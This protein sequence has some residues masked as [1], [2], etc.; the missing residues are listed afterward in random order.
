MVCWLHFHKWFNFFS[1]RSIELRCEAKQNGNAADTFNC[2]EP[3]DKQCSHTCNGSKCLQVC[4][5]EQGTC[6][7]KCES[8]K[9]TQTCEEGICDLKC[10]GIYC[11]QT[12]NGDCILECHAGRCKQTC[13]ALNDEGTC[14]AHCPVA[15][16]ASKCQQNCP[17]KEPQCTKNFITIT[18][19]PTLTGKR[20]NESSIV[21]RGPALKRGEGRRREAPSSFSSCFALHPS[22]F[23]TSWC[24]FRSKLGDINRIN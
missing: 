17:G 5:N 6:K 22:Y 10:N 18:E 23:R 4:N 11:R 8:G 20:S 19:G 24:L 13:S 16:H 3:T 15:G 21:L 1:G 7:L 9:C 2:N 14:K 12:C